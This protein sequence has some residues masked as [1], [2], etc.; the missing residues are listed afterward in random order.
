MADKLGVPT[1]TSYGS[2]YGKYGG[3]KLSDQIDPEPKTKS[4]NNRD[5]TETGEW[6]PFERTVK[7]FVFA[8][9]GYP[10]VDVELEDFQVEICIE[11]AIS[12]LEYHSPDWLTQYAS[13]QTSANINVY[14]LPAEV[15][16]NLNDVWYQRDFF[17]F[18][19]SP[20]SLEYDFSIMFFTNSGMFNNY[21]VS[22]YLLMQQ[23]LKQV[24]NVLGKA[25]S[26]QLINNRYLHIFPVPESNEEGVLLE[27]RALDAETVHPAYKNWIQ[28]YS[29]A[30][31][32]EILGRI[33]GKYQTL[34]GPSGGSRLDGDTLLSE[35]REEKQMLIE[36]LKT[37]IE[38]PP[39]FDIF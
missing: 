11:E 7:D 33:R 3:N 24:K 8:R 20:G 10:V 27:F 17:K 21:N 29:L 14:E 25:S 36:E 2:S 13:F 4:L 28:R 15:A 26:W 19:A 37:E 38:Q 6:K 32:K 18:G 22:Q 34:P 5:A 16:N 12:K 30:V 39:L 31:S 9:L 35:S 1:L 23:Y